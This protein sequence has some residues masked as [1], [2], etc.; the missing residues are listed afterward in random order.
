MWS[1]VEKLVVGAPAETN[2]SPDGER[3]AVAGA[4][5][6]A[7]STVAGSAL[8][9]ATGDRIGTALANSAETSTIVARRRAFHPWDCCIVLALSPVCVPPQRRRRAT[10][11]HHGA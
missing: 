8:A 7:A 9:T 5:V 1:A 6:P 2:V 4:G 11:D 10:L 3:M